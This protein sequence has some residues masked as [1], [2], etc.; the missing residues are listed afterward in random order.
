MKGL[1]VILLILLIPIAIVAA[2][3]SG[4]LEFIIGTLTFLRDYFV[5]I[6]E[7]TES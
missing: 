1:V 7:G 6:K 4:L 2:I 5:L 3:L